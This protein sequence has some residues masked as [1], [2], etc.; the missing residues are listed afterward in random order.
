MCKDRSSAGGEEGQ[1]WRGECLQ[2]THSHTERLNWKDS[3]DHVFERE[4]TDFCVG[5]QLDRK[6]TREIALPN[7]RDSTSLD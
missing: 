7:A 2:G 4:H 1:P 5:N 3:M 6:Q